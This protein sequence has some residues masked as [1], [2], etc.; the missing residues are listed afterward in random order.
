MRARVHLLEPLDRDMRID[1]GRRELRMAQHLLEIADVGAGIMHQRRH[2]VAKD[3]HA[4]GFVMPAPTTYW[5]SR[6]VSFVARMR[7]PRALR[8]SACVSSEVIDR[9]SNRVRT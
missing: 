1:L 3:V 8:K 9:M 2:R 7:R 5:W 6:S 4:P